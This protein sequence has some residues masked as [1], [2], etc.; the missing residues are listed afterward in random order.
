MDGSEKDVRLGIA[1]Q[2]QLSQTALCP[3]LCVSDRNRVHIQSF[4]FPMPEGIS[5]VFTPQC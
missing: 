1:E 4:L 2:D 5:G 3:G